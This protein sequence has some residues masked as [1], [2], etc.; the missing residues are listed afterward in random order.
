MTFRFKTF[1]FLNEIQQKILRVCFV[2]MRKVT[3]ASRKS[4]KSFAFL[5]RSKFL[6]AKAALPST[7]IK[8][9][10]YSKERMKNWFIWTRVW[11]VLLGT[12]AN[13]QVSNLLYKSLKR[14]FGAAHFGSNFLHQN[15]TNQNLDFRFLISNIFATSKCNL[16]PLREN[17]YFQ[18]MFTVCCRFA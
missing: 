12:L 10:K 6:K 14:A 1:I 4:P 16:A 17:L 5:P 7:A 18:G 8:I 3:L 15:Q 9:P 13:I 2:L 11:E